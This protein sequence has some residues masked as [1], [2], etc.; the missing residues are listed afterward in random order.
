MFNVNEENL[1][2]SRAL[3]VL[4]DLSSERVRQL[5]DEGLFS[6]VMKSGKKHFDVTKSVQAYIRSLK[7]KASASGDDPA[8]EAQIKQAEMRY[9]T[10]RAG[11]VE[12]ELQELQ[13]TMHRAEDVEL[14]T[15]DMVAKLRGAFLA[16]P[17]RLAVD[18]ANAKT[19]REASALIK[20]AVDEVLNDTAEYCYHAEA[21]RE[22][23]MEREKWRSVKEAEEAL[24]KTK[25]GKSGK[26]KP[27][28][29]SSGSQK[30]SR[31]RK[32]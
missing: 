24:E 15:G 12:L 22:R 20:A 32:T 10:A 21:Y 28:G 13:G 26:G 4:L 11:K 18:A 9:K 8:T 16:L 25:G 31:R 3:G 6:C 1:I 29:S 5:E 7:D 17:G 19:A 27:Q 30:A 2:T 14:I 23:V